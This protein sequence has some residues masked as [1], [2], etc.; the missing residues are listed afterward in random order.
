MPNPLTG[1]HRSPRSGN[2]AKQLVV[3]LHGWGADGYNL[4]DLADMFAETLPDAYFIAPNGPEVCEVNPYGFQWFSLL[5]RRPD[6]MFAGARAA[7]AVL[8]QFLDA[9]Q[10]ELNLTDAQTALVGFSQ[11]TMLSLHTAL[12]RTPSLACMVGFSGAL[13]GT[14]SLAAEMKST[15]PVCLIHGQMDE[16]V[17]F[18]AMPHAEAALKAAGV[19]VESHPRP[20]LGHS[21][22][23]EGMAIAGKFLKRHLNL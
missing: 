17:P 3:I 13:L 18:A 12:R 4:I 2:A 1:P 8:N 15:L 7:E 10:K 21:I 14:E 16:V 9:K 5:D 20:M 11:G 22:D 6:I 23:M 19:R